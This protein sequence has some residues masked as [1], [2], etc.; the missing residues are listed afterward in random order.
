MHC[1]YSNTKITFLPSFTIAIIYFTYLIY[2]TDMEISSKKYL[3]YCT[4]LFWLY[5]T[6]KFENS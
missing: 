6:Q 5:D 1:L 2:P 3:Y 4:V